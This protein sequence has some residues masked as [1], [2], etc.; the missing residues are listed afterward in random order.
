MGEDEVLRRLISEAEAEQERGQ[1]GMTRFIQRWRKELQAMSG[2]D[3]SIVDGPGSSSTPKTPP[4]VPHLPAVPPMP[5][6]QVLE[7]RNLN[8]EG[9]APAG[10]QAAA[11][12]ISTPSRS[13]PP[14]PLRIAPPGLYRDVKAGRHAGAGG[15]GEP[16]EQIAKAL[17]NQTAELASLVRNQVEGAGTQPQGTIKGLGRQ[18][19]ELVF[20]L[21]ACGQYEVKIGEGEHGQALANSLLAAQ[22]GASTKLRQAGFKQKMTPR[23]AIGLAGPYWGVQE[24]F[25]LSAADFVSFTDAELDQFASEAARTAKQGA[26]QRPPQPTGSRRG[27]CG[28]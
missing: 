3:W 19:E 5:V 27:S 22:V 12:E 24:R 9:E 20:L 17:Q 4:E 16:M 26:D 8:V 14:P 28:I 1:R 18:S 10:P 6:R 15:E 13:D 7:G 2:S 11:P 23:L 21:R 25:A